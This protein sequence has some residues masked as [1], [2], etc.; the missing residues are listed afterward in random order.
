[1][2]LHAESNDIHQADILY[3]PHDKYKKEI[4]KYASNIVD[5]ASRYKGSYQ[6]QHQAQQKK[7]QKNG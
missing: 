2:S 4:C 3:L 1:M 6:L 5:V 7:R